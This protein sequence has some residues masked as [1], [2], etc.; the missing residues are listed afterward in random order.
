MNSRIEV[1]V[2]VVMEEFVFRVRELDFRLMGVGLLCS[3]ELVFWDVLVG[4]GG[5]VVGFGRVVERDYEVSSV[6]VLVLK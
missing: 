1:L 2:G 5:V 6:R 3:R 4:K